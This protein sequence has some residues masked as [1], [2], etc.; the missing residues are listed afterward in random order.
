MELLDCNRCV[1]AW[2][3]FPGEEV[4][5]GCEAADHAAVDAISRLVARKAGQEAVVQ[6]I[7]P[8]SA[9]ARASIGREPV[10]C[11]YAVAG[12]V[13]PN[14]GP[15][16]VF[17]AGWRPTALSPKE[18]SCLSRAVGVVW[19]AL[20]RAPHRQPE[21]DLPALLEE[22]VFPAFIV[23]E[24]LHVQDLNSSGRRLLMSGDPLK[25][26]NGALAGLN[27]SITS[28]LKEAFLHT[29]TSRSEPA[30]MNT[31]V[32]L[33]TQHPHFAF[34]WIGPVPT[35]P[36]TN[37]ALI[38]APQVDT[39]A[40]ARR[41]A[42]AFALSWAEERIVARI[43]QGQSPSCI[44]A[45]LRLTEATVRTY[46]KRIMLKLGIN[47]QSEFFVLYILTL[48]P[49]GAGQRER[50]L[51]C[52]QPYSRLYGGASRADDA[53]DNGDRAETQLDAE[54]SRPR[55]SRNWRSQ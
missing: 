21:T 7:G 50:I 53:A 5:L 36:D 25:I 1:L 19:S 55:R 12:A 11:A 13:A 44:G 54:V 22:L 3:R 6:S 41:I 42:A 40:G 31:I 16:L 9:V 51:S 28:R 4:R 52:L 15:E 39:A 43:L 48:S 26:E 38:L 47:R 24:R 46:T 27:A 17:L 20:G 35:Q 14:D 23:D 29:R 37:Q 34:A 45:A 32:T 2:V 49:F 18:I 30:W 33:S 10:G 8:D